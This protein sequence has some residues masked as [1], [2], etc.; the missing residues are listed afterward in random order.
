MSF[1]A[2][3]DRLIQRDA[4]HRII[5]FE[6]LDVLAENHSLIFG[7]PRAPVLFDRQSAGEW[8]AD[9]ASQKCSPSGTGNEVYQKLLHETVFFQVLFWTHLG[10]L[11]RNEPVCEIREREKSH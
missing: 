9:G 7:Q 2:Q 1:L 3:F 11:N 5:G 4:Q 6:F 10:L 8:G